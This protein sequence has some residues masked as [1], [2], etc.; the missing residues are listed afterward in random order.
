M[1]VSWRFEK[2][3]PDSSIE[4]FRFVKMLPILITLAVIGF[5]IHS[6]EQVLISGNTLYLK[7]AP[8]DPRSIM[9]GDY[10]RLRYELVRKIPQAGVQNSGSLIL[11]L[12]EQRVGSFVRFDNG[13]P[14]QA[15]QLRILY[16]NHGEVKIGAE[17]YFFQ[18]GQADC[19]EL[20]EYAELRVSNQGETLLVG[21]ADTELRPIGAQL[22][23]NK[24]FKTRTNSC[25]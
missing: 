7:L 21:L 11:A 2:L 6:K 15:D 12:D 1:K 18:E 4:P 13:E 10:M 22:H 14:L 16:K 3:L 25:G 23:Q 9:Q 17:N 5:V 24:W 20:A 8:V 19:H